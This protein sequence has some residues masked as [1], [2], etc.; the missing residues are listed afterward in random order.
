MPN[1]FQLKSIY[2]Y[3]TLDQQNSYSKNLLAIDETYLFELV[4]KKDT[5]HNTS[6]TMYKAASSIHLTIFELTFIFMSLSPL[7]CSTTFNFIL[8]K[9]T[10]VCCTIFVHCKP[11]TVL[12]VS[13][14]TTFI[15]G[16]YP[17]FIFLSIKNLK[18]LSMPYKL[19]Y[20]RS[21]FSI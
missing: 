11:L 18:A 3:S 19:E 13:I 21:L 6:I 14:P 4:S 2:S 10:I 8:S 17:F 9:C 20:L 15:F 16:Q 5:F 12:S 1:V 7:K